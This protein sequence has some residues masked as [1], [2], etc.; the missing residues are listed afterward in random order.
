MRG[1]V[2]TEDEEE[3]REK[4]GTEGWERRTLTS[5]AAAICREAVR[6]KDRRH[7]LP[8]YFV[9]GIRERRYGSDVSENTR[10]DR[11]VRGRK[12]GRIEKSR[13][14]AIKRREEEEEED[15]QF[16]RIR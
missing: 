8:R 3:R 9:H 10:E 13:S 15:R 6:A 1:K 12:D 2:F 4:S 11:D 5:L 7:P 16:G 14:K